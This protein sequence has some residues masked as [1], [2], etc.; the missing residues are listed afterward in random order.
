MEEIGKIIFLSSN[1][2]SQAAGELWKTNK[3]NSM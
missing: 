1:G 2:K 3:K